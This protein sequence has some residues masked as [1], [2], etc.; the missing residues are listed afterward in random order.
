MPCPFTFAGLWEGWKDPNGNWIKTCSILTTTTNSM[1]SAV[2][3]RMPVIL[4]PGDYDVWL[5]PG[6]K[7]AMVVSQL[8]KPFDGSA[9]RRYPVSRRVNVVQNDD[10]EC[11]KAVELECRSDYPLFT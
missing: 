6:M 5:D 1:I 8:L 4:E 3:D 9:L 2:H 7:D 10:E 11:S